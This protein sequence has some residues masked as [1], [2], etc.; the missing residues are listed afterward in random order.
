MVYNDG[1][2][3]GY[4]IGMED[5]LMLTEFGKTLRKIRIDRNEILKDMAEKLGVTVSYLS[6]VENGKREVP[7]TWINDISYWYQLSELEKEML[8]ESAFNSKKKISLDLNN[9]NANQREAAITFAREFKELSPS[10]IDE[11]L[12]TFKKFKLED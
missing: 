11:L 10:E 7:D 5:R 4:T 2:G 6:A 8:R 3:N 12:E 9:L 1:E